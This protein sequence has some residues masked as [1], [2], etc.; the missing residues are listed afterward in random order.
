M[1][2]RLMSDRVPQNEPL[3]VSMVDCDTNTSA[4][5]GRAEGPTADGAVQPFITG[6]VETLIA[7]TGDIAKTGVLTKPGDLADAEAAVA[8]LEKSVYSLTA[9]LEETLLE[10]EALHARCGWGSG[11]R[12]QGSGFGGQ[13]S[14]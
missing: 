3:R 10:N 2:I 7:K 1:Q 6:A 9:F 13:G 5:S 14:G 4:S 8:S 11:S 12:V